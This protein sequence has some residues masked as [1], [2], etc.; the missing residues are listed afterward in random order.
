MKK[1]FIISII[2]FAISFA[3]IIFTI[4]SSHLNFKTVQIITFI[5]LAI[6]LLSFI[7]GQIIL[8]PKKIKEYKLI[9]SRLTSIFKFY[10]PTIF[11]TCFFTNTSW[12]ILNIFPG[13]DITLAYAL[14]ILFI[15]WFVLEIRHMKSKLIYINKKHIIVSNYFSINE[16]SIH[17]VSEVNRFF[18]INI[19]TITIENETGINK[20]IFLPKFAETTI[21]FITPESIKILRSYIGKNDKL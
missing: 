20:L 13:K 1:K 17:E 2:I 10:L 18:I 15:A 6:L 16:Y 3:V 5:S 4:F 8:Y 11:I 7:Y 12:I 21:P 14:D 9:S 19:Y